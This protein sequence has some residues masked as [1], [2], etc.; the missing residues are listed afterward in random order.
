MMDCA[1]NQPNIWSRRTVIR[2]LRAEEDNESIHYMQHESNDKTIWEFYLQRKGRKLQA[3]WSLLSVS[4]LIFYFCPLL[5]FSLSTNASLCCHSTS[6][7]QTPLLSHLFIL[8][9]E[10]CLSPY[11]LHILFY[12]LFLPQESP[13]S[14]SAPSGTSRRKQARDG[15]VI[16]TELKWIQTPENIKFSIEKWNTSV[17]YSTKTCLQWSSN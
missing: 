9:W 1:S 6:R 10:P 5:S 11:S 17:V 13:V 4:L 3:L 8:S 7:Y 16:W 14:S 15:N 12:F 2:K